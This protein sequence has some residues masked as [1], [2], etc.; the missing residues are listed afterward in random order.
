MSNDPRYVFDTNVLVSAALFNTSVPGQALIRAL[1]SGTILTSCSLIEELD[2]VLR[3]DKLK[4]YLTREEREQ[5]LEA[6]IRET[7]LVEITESVVACR[8][9]KDDRLLELALCG[10][11]SLIVT[12]DDDLMV[13]NP[14]RGVPIVT[15]SE[16]LDRRDVRTNPGE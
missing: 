10:N 5:F 9:P 16:M 14:F 6:L 3:R 13:M 7:E 8:D 15:P 2:N 4:R 12:G 11:A 1:E